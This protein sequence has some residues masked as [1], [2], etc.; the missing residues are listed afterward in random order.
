MI[1]PEKIGPTAAQKAFLDA[2][3]E[4]DLVMIVHDFKEHFG[5]DDVTAYKLLEWWIDEP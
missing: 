5:V 4:A 2:R 1:K 3:I